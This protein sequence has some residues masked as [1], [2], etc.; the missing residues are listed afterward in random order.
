MKKDKIINHVIIWGLFLIPCSLF[1]LTSFIDFAFY[2]YYFLFIFPIVLYMKSEN[3]KSMILY[4]LL[5]Y[6]ILLGL[7]KYSFVSINLIPFG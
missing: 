5:F 2:F 4:F 3:R 7:F 1:F 6:L